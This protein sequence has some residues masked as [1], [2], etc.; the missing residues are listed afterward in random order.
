MADMKETIEWCPH[1][2]TECT[3]HPTEDQMIGTCTN[4]GRRIVLCDKCCELNPNVGDRQCEDCKFC[5][6]ANFMNYLKGFVTVEK[7]L[8]SLN[9]TLTDMTTGVPD[10]CTPTLDDYIN[11]T[12]GDSVNWD[13]KY[14]D[15]YRMVKECF[16]NEES[17]EEECRDVVQRIIEKNR[18]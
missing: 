1:C 15:I 3:F 8:E 14:W 12:W 7:F 13:V 17:T 11:D 6:L 9:P 10:G 4:C 16:L 5:D 18:E 2:D